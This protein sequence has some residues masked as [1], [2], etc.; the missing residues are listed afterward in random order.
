[1]P[2]TKRI[3]RL[4]RVILRE[5][6][7]GVLRNVSDENKTRP[8]VS[9][10]ICNIAKISLGQRSPNDTT[11]PKYDERSHL[12]ILICFVRSALHAIRLKSVQSCLVRY[13]LSPDTGCQMLESRLGIA[14]DA[15]RRRNRQIPPMGVKIGKAFPLCGLC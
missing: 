1:M 10:R 12:K 2:A 5:S 13:N 3:A 8:P 14:N 4:F 9:G 6:V 15:C 11:R 7:H